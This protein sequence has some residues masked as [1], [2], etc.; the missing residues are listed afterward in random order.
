MSFSRQTGTPL[1]T[2]PEQASDLFYNERTDVYT[3]GIILFEMLNN[4]KTMH[5]RIDKIMKLK[6]K[7]FIEEPFK[8]K[9]PFETAL[10]QRLTEKENDNR[11]KCWEIFKLK[12]FES[13]VKELSTNLN[14]DKSLTTADSK[15]DSI[16]FIHSTSP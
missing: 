8:T 16:Q 10:I 11:P 1:Y 2:A 13:W 7:G 4:F 3:L 15:N 9:Y 12:E 5:M 6:D 14:L